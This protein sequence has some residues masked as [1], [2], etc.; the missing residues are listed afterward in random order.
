[1]YDN[2]LVVGPNA[3]SV[4]C[5]GNDCMT[6]STAISLLAEIAVAENVLTQIDNLRTYPIV[7]SRLNQGSLRLHAW[8]YEFETGEVYAYDPLKQEYV[9]PEQTW[10]QPT[11]A[12]RLPHQ[13]ATACDWLP[14]EQADRIYRG[15]H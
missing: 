1:M 15:S 8:V 14:E 12:F 2:V 5:R 6:L 10:N 11:P 3:S 4:R 9:S 13:V 7:R